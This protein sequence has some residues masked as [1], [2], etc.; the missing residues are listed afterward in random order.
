MKAK[1]LFLATVVIATS[2]ISASA[3]EPQWSGRVIA[4]GAERAAIEAT[5]IEMRPNRP[6]HFYGNTGRRQYY[7]GSAVPAP[8]DFSNGAGSLRRR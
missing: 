1:E 6:L 8:R 3:Q 4:T 7:R 2:T 5:P